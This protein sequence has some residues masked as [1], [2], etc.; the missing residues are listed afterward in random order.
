MLVD[1]IK[2]LCMDIGIPE[3]L[4]IA[5]NQA[6]KTGEISREAIES[7]IEAM[8]VDAMKS[9]NIA[10]NPRSSRQCDIEMLYRKAL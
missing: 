8:A 9:G 5:V 10:V 1:A 6:S 4:T 7:K 3:T 2:Q